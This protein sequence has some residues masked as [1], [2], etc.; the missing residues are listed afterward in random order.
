[1]STFAHYLNFHN[2]RDQD[3]ISALLDLSRFT[4]TYASIVKSKFTL[5][6]LDSSLVKGNSV[7]DA[8]IAKE[9]DHSEFALQPSFVDNYCNVLT[10]LLKAMAEDSDHEKYLAVCITKTDTLGFTSSN[11]WKLLERVFGH[12]IFELFNNY[13]NVF[14][15]EIFATSAVGYTIIKGGAVPNYSNGKIIN[16]IDWRPLNCAAPFFWLFENREIERIKSASNFLSREANLR[17]YIRYPT[18]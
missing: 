17:N 14:R 4:P 9:G 13:R 18:S 10:I 8:D 15:I 1:M 12:K 7:L 5:L 2:S 16:P 3:L 6:L 11:S